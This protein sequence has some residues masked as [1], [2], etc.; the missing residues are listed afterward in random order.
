LARLSHVGFQPFLFFFP[1]PSRSDFTSLEALWLFLFFLFG[2]VGDVT[3]ISD[4]P[5]SW[6]LIRAMFCFS[7]SLTWSFRS[8]T[9]MTSCHDLPFVPMWTFSSFIA[10]DVPFLPFQTLPPSFIFG[11]GGFWMGNFYEFSLRFFVPPTNPLKPALFSGLLPTRR[12]AR[13]RLR[14]P[15]KE[16][17][18]FSPSHPSEIPP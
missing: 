18:L 15:K 8:S 9:Y 2:Q 13:P 14:D 12:A 16:V 3:P 5:F 4:S 11:V 1:S 6:D 7:F 10:T 17:R